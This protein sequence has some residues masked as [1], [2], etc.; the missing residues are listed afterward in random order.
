LPP[1]AGSDAVHR[2]ALANLHLFS[3]ESPEEAAFHQR[4]AWSLCWPVAAVQADSAGALQALKMQEAQASLT[5]NKKTAAALADPRI[6][7]VAHDQVP[8][9]ATMERAFRLAMAGSPWEALGEVRDAA[10]DLYGQLETDTLINPSRQL[11]G[12]APIKYEYHPWSQGVNRG[13]E[14]GDHF[15]HGLGAG[16]TDVGQKVDD[17]FLFVDDVV[18]HRIVQTTVNLARNL[19]G[20][21][22]VDLH[23]EDDPLHRAL[24]RSKEGYRRCGDELDPWHD[25]ASSAGRRAGMAGGT[26]VLAVA[27]PIAGAAAFGLMGLGDAAEREK[28]RDADAA[29]RGEAPVYG[30]GRGDMAV[31]ANGGLQA[32]L[33]LAGPAARL[34]G[35]TRFAAPLLEKLGQIS[36]AVGKEL[37]LFAPRFAARLGPRASALV[38]TTGAVGRTAA[39]GAAW[40]ASST[41]AANLSEKI[42]NPKHH[43]TEGVGEALV[44]GA[45]FGA[46]AHMLAMAGVA[47]G[48]LAANAG[49]KALA[50]ASELRMAG[51]AS[52]EARAQAQVFERLRKMVAEQPLRRR[53]PQALASIL[54]RFSETGRVFAPVKS[55]ISAV[56]R[57]KLG[58]SEKSALLDHTGLPGPLAAVDAAKASGDPA[59]AAIA[60]EG[61][62]AF[63]AADYLTGAGQSPLHAELAPD[64][65]FSPDGLSLRDAE[66]ID[67]AFRHIAPEDAP[68]VHAL[69]ET[70]PSAEEAAFTDRYHEEVLS[71][72][73]PMEAMAAAEAVVD[74]NAGPGPFQ[75]IT[76]NIFAASIRDQPEGPVEGVRHQAGETAPP[77]PHARG[78]FPDASPVPE[79]RPNEQNAPP[80]T[81]EDVGPFLDTGSG[82]AYETQLETKW[83][84]RSRS[85]HF[86]RAAAA[87]DA[88]LRDPQFAAMMEAAIPGITEAV[89]RRGG[90]KAPDG[91]TWHHASSSTAGGRFGVMRLVPREHHSPGSVEYRSLHPDRGAGGGYAEWAIPNGAPPNRGANSR[92]K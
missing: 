79:G 64:L 90:R 59:L 24:E 49:A 1:E 46:A 61:Q 38:Q 68:A 28:Q 3:L 25:K 2:Q 23:S 47:G 44:G 73:S 4:L 37:S 21:D 83:F 89:S 91:W 78:L 11:L 32:M 41:V 48:R 51:A 15:L 26:L 63:P 14:A 19:A 70:P 69:L 13:L 92:R 87:L 7:A 43:L 16:L 35:R 18:R 77:E 45:A 12:W 33:A 9:I 31:L 42:Y 74:R 65:R 20:R 40:G 8:R 34:A 57:L 66:A 22:S 29:A 67:T 60:H 10:V 36:P 76:E 39:A 55:V 62:F 54:S 5:E 85:V 75:A 84:G 27:D 71:G 50:A 88:A 58:P 53:A 52:L 82:F 56:E 30:T 6:A 86:N 17:G 72:Q 81:R 80:P